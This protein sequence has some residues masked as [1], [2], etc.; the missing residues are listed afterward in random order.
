LKVRRAK[1]GRKEVTCVLVA[2]VSCCDGSIVATWSTL[3]LPGC[4]DG[5]GNGVPTERAAGRQDDVAVMLA[6]FELGL[7]HQNTSLR[8]FVGFL[9]PSKTASS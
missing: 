9:S 7:G 8:L 5:A 4:V 6:W 1:E 3:P 2:G